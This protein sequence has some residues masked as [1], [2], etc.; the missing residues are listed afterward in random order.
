M[1]TARPAFVDNLDVHDAS[2][3]P[4]SQQLADITAPKAEM[5]RLCTQICNQ[6][7]DLCCHGGIKTTLDVLE[8]WTYQSFSTW[9]SMDMDE[10]RL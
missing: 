1:L 4:V 8:Q 9:R 10:A 7:T 6:A 3:P 5:R 2:A